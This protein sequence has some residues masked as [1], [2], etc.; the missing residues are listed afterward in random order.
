MVVNDTEGADL[1]AIGRDDGDSCVEPPLEFGCVW[2][3]A[4]PRIFAQVRHDKRRLV[5]AFLY[6]VEWKIDR[7]LTDTSALGDHDGAEVN[8]ITWVM[9]RFGL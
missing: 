5:L 9:D 6:R 8:L 2:L 4:E 3:V 7:V 1:V